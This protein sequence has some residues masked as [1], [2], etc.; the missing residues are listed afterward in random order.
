[1]TDK[2]EVEKPSLSQPPDVSS[3]PQ[4]TLNFAARMFA[5]ARTG[6]DDSNELLAAALQHGLPPNLRNDQ[7]NTLLLLAAYHGHASTVRLLLSHKA[8]PN[9]LNDRDQSAV[10]GAVYKNEK[11]IVEDLLDGG[12]DPTIGSPSA[13]ETAKLFSNETLAT[14]MEQKSKYPSP[15]AASTEEPK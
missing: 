9:I 6:D 11:E 10:A 14:L 2:A 3:L 15:I 8:D 1:M 7:G 4:E 12:A 5:A 13:I